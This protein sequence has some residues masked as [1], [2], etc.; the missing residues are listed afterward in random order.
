MLLCFDGL[1]KI[2][3]CLRLELKMLID[4]AETWRNATVF[5]IKL[6][7]NP[8]QLLIIRDISSQRKR[9][10]SPSFSYGDKVKIF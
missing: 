4:S 10:A 6:T 7:T 1:K 5:P 2:I 9:Y 8:V 3:C